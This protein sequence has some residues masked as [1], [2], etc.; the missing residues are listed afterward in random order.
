[1]SE[2]T[3]EKA[4]N[5]MVAAGD[6]PLP[7]SDTMIELVQTLINEKEAEF[8]PLFTK[9]MT[10]DQV[11]EVT[12]LN[13]EELNEILNSLMYKGVV[14]GI[15]SDS[16]GQVI[17]RLMPPLPGAFEY[18]L[19]RGGKT[20]KD[21]KMAKLFDK[22][23]HDVKDMVD[24]NF[25]F[26]MGMFKGT[27]P[28]TRVVPIN[29]AVV[30]KAEAGDIIIPHENINDIVDKFD[31]I[32]LVTCYCR[33]EQDL[34]GNPCKLTDNRKNC[35]LFGKTGQFAI[36]Y[37]F[38]H[39][40]SSDEAKKIFAQSTEEGLVHKSFHVQGDIQKDEY[41]ICNCCKCCCGTIGKYN[42]GTLPNHVYAS[43][44]AQVDE[45]E[46][47]SCELCVERCPV[48]AISFDDVAVIDTEKCFGCGVCAAKC[49]TEAITLKRTGPRELF[50]PPVRNMEKS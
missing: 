47:I 28:F 43:H 20:E 17:Y 29:H 12:I 41:A 22:L 1:M 34:L 9:S 25:D 33:H 32:A 6:I 46:C 42:S 23:F 35:M 16:D 31:T 36:D 18:N 5:A 27:K 2:N 10:L 49:P 30:E 19:M 3:W 21:V 24:E 38:G 44:I 13:E 14:T 39:K 37:D 15:P 7:I 11:K 40:I 8:I 45:S 4:A 50:I 26:V 48:E